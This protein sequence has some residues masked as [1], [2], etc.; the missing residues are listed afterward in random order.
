[1]KIV[2]AYQYKTARNWGISIDGKSLLIALIVLFFAFA[3]LKYKVTVLEIDRAILTA[4][5]KNA[6]LSSLDRVE[7][8]FFTKAVV[9]KINSNGA[10]ADAGWEIY[11]RISSLGSKMPVIAYIDSV[12]ASGGYLISLPA[13]Y[14]YAKPASEV[15]SIGAVAGVPEE[16]DTSGLVVSGP[17]KLQKTKEMVVEQV[18]IIKNEF[19][20]AVV[21]HRNSK[22]KIDPVDLTTGEVYIGIKAMEIGLIDRF[23]STADAVAAAADMANLIFYNVERINPFEEKGT[24]LIVL[25]TSIVTNSTTIPEYY[26]LYINTGEGV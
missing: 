12:G 25:K 2:V 21:K 4:E 17:F 26:H 3:A 16:M 20:S 18:N 7:N 24:G 14:I 15:G 22:L 1:M 19:L 5:E 11:N 9:L 6:V 13:Q 10:T 23:G 8:D